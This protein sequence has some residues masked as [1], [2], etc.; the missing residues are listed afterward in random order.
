MGLGHM[1]PVHE[2]GSN[3]SSATI[4][5]CLFVGNIVLQASVHGR[6]ELQEDCK[7]IHHDTVT[8]AL[9]LSQQKKSRF[10]AR[11]RQNINIAK[12]Q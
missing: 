7:A 10:V 2:H 3:E 6:M 1:R 9:I 12:K 11:K 5:N 8:S 4:H